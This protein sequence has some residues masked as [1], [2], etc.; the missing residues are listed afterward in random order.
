MSTLSAERL[1]LKVGD[2]LLCENLELRIQAGECWGILG[3]NGCG[4]TTLLHTLAGLLPPATGRITLQGQPL[5]Q[6]GR[7]N[8]ARRCGLLLQESHDPFPATVWETVL[9][10][11]HPHLGRWQLESR[12]DH[13]LAEAALAQ[14]DLTPL[15]SRQVQNLSGGERRRLAFATLLTQAPP[16]LLLDEPLN[17]LDLRHQRQLL[18]VVS[19]LCRNGSTVMM[20]LHDPNQATSGCDHLLLLDGKGGW[21]ADTASRLLNEETLSRLYRCPIETVEHRGRRLFYYLD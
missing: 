19:S 12:D 3:P 16:L 14:M 7:R 20:V 6:L 8:I 13:A 18:Q 9:S 15:A 11:R 2:R 17:H 10:G 5:E 1:S 21:Q 4:K